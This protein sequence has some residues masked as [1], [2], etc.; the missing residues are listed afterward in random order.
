MR[1]HYVQ[2]RT[3][4]KMLLF[5]FIFCVKGSLDHL[6]SLVG[7]SS[8]EEDLVIAAKWVMDSAAI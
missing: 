1:S 6:S 3:F 8:F 5:Y 2:I 4:V 7:L